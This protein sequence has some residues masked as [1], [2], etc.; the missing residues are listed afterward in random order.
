MDGEDERT[1]GGSVRGE[2]RY[3]V[4]VEMCGEK[5]VG[6]GKN[7]LVEYWRGGWVIVGEE[8]EMRWREYVRGAARRGMGI[9]VGGRLDGTGNG[10]WGGR[11]GGRLC[12]MIRVGRRDSLG[13]GERRGGLEG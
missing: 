3:G 5:G 6:R 7:L 13:K 4:S 9:G 1:M 2:R 11:E 10:R 12:V 8:G